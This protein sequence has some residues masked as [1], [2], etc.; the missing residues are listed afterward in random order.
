VISRLRNRTSTSS[1]HK[2]TANVNSLQSPFR[3]AG[4]AFVLV[5]MLLLAAPAA[6]AAGA[7]WAAPAWGLQITHSPETFDRY[8]GEH[9]FTLT[10]TNTGDVPTGDPFTL[11]ARL[12]EDVTL[13]G[14][15]PGPFLSCT[16]NG[17]DPTPLKCTGTQ[18]L[19]P[20]ESV[21]VEMEVALDPE[22]PETATIAAEI[23]GGD[24]TA[25][26][27]SGSAPVTYPPF[28]LKSFASRNVD[29]SDNVVSAAGA[30]PYVTLTQFL[31][32]TMHGGGGGR[33]YEQFKDAGVD[34][35]NG[36][37]GNP[38]AL[39]RC[40]IPSIPQFGSGAPCPFGSRLGS[41]TVFSSD[42]LT[43]SDAGSLLFNVKPAYGYPAQFAFNTGGT[44]ASLYV[45]FR[46]RTEN[47]GVT[48][49]AENAP[50]FGLTGTTT[51]FWGV[52]TDH[53]SGTTGAPFLSNP[54]SCSEE[55]PTWRV[56]TD[57]WKT[58]GRRHP[59]NRPDLGDPD[60]LTATVPA[61]QATG[62]DN[63]ALV[64]QFKPTL[65]AK[66]LQSGGPIQAD[67]PAGLSVDFDFP[68]SND[69][70]DLNTTFDAS[71]PQAPEPKDITTTLPAGFGISPSSAA[72]LEACSDLA[73]DPAGDQVHYD[74]IAPI[75]CPDAS[76]IGSINLITPTLAAHDPVDDH[77]VGPDPVGGSVYLLKPHPGDL[78]TG[79]GKQE[80]K[81][82][83]LI[84]VSSP[85]YG[86]NFKI[87]GVATADPNTGRLSATF[88]RN[89]QLPASHIQVN[90]KSGPR[91]PLASPVTCGTYTT[92]SDIVPWSTPG[93]PTEHP[94][95]T[96]NVSSGPGGSACP[97]SPAARPFS[98]ALIAGMDSNA[99]GKYS[100]FVLR[101]NRGDGEQEL[102]TID[103]TTPKGFSAKLAGVP[104]CPE[105]AIAAA[106]SKSGLAEQSNPSCP[107]AS[108]IGTVTAG[109]G[110][111]T[112]P[113][114]AQ[115]KAYL[116]G[117]YKGAPL[118]FAFITPAVAGPFDLGTTVVRAAAFVDPET[119][120]VT[121]KTDPL[122]QIIDGVP[123]KIR[124]ITARLDRQNFTI[125]PTNCQAMSVSAVVGSSNGATANPSNPFQVGGC[126]KLGFKPKL[127]LA[128]KGGT[129]RGD[130]PA[131]KA[132][133]S[134]PSGAYANIAKAQVTL[135]HSEF[136]EQSHIKTICTRVQF[137]AKACPAASVYG[138]A[139][140]T[141]P[142]LDAPLSGPVY[143][144]SS[145]HQLPDLVA[146]LNGQIHVA[147]AG[148]IDSVKGGIRATFEAVPDAPV[149]KFT[150]EMQGGKKG[151]LVNSGNICKTGNRA[152]VDLDAQNGLSYDTTPLL[153]NGCKKSK[154]SKGAKGKAH[155]RSAA[156]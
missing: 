8:G 28:G 82:R 118:S 77:I 24:A 112:N 20:G 153:A 131:L 99:A 149:S 21:S 45:T 13:S 54:V 27:A 43:V 74:N 39:P 84:L 117:P 56:T 100:P 137:A 57:S 58:T 1:M 115:G 71:I 3:L 12:G 141:T 94:S 124:S 7:G 63:P 145:S 78:P 69:P 48:V 35:P 150:L 59:D 146:D 60:W 44:V 64:S 83:L 140:A 96:F 81:F 132:T 11:T 30:H 23:A 138:K 29:A 19:A 62:C 136:L 53:G 121:T 101:I 103:V 123:L 38:A 72:G 93:T 61:A 32:T 127:K 128:L 47:Y 107:A 129:K 97:S 10:A 51:H 2:E 104:Y 156:R 52:P 42:P 91:A 50:P 25:V 147:L 155:K 86:I 34:L 55:D 120:Q 139:T 49:G 73:S 76:K 135:P 134:Y 14:M 110:P 36:F 41:A 18:P 5:G 9:S 40:P 133:L 142:L 109:A 4:L 16:G 80:G 106:A 119:A 125:N 79:G 33:S 92:N 116:A 26:V 17:V 152:T 113:Y 87:P 22:V 148:R 98:P 89:P 46:P 143:L 85:R 31:F 37:F 130:Y 111:G 6:Q 67:Q 15:N 105:A 154:K 108:Q 122:P 66:P 70:T 68:Q 102:N 95:S 90:L 88:T 65:G 151:L 114:Y 144:R 126:D 75:T